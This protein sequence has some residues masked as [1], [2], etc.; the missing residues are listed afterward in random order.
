MYQASVIIPTH[1]R[2][3]FLG[4][5]LQSVVDQ[6]GVELD[7]IVVGDG[8]GEETEA[9][10]ARFPGV[11][12]IWQP[13]SGPNAARNRAV[14]Q[15]R[16][17]YIAMLDDDDLWLPGKLR[18]QL[19]ILEQEPEAAYIFSDFHILRE[20]HP[21]I[22]NGLSTWGIPDTAL[23]ALLRDPA[24][25]IPD[26]G[27]DGLGDRP[28]NYYRTDLYRPLVEH[29]YVL[30][31]TAVFRKSFLTPDIRFV[32]SDYTCGD[33]EFFARLSR[34]YKALYMP[35]ET[36][37]NRSHEETGRLTRLSDLIQLQRRVDMLD[38]LWLKDADFLAD[39]V[40]RSIV[41]QTKFGYL[42]S[43]AKLQLRNHLKDAAMSTLDTAQAIN[44]VLP[45]SMRV[46][47]MLARIPGGMNCL[48]GIDKAI[49]KT[50]NLLGR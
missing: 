7:I 36:A 17:D 47:R 24:G 37:H 3:H 45:H 4:D 29:P 23:A 28:V 19:E 16:Y 26:R 32:D 42:I 1:K 25:S 27:L 18:T 43:L 20:G 33:W 10:T 34:S 14:A 21:L 44:P 8:T 15:A 5:A 39:S 46:A 12:Y 11:R 38:R 13:Q 40:N 49:S 41:M 6:Q 35:V 48:F 22:P 31:T 50:R 9:V 30:P 2:P